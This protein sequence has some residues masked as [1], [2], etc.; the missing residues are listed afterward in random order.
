MRDRILA[1]SR[2]RERERRSDGDG[3]GTRQKP[4]VCDDTESNALLLLGNILPDTSC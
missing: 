3:N 1:V 4:E 2:E